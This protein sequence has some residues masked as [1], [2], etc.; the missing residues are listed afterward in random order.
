[1]S[2]NHS[3][4]TPKDASENS[5]LASLVKRFHERLL[6]VEDRTLDVIESELEEAIE[7]EATAEEMARDE[8]DLLGAYLRRDI[9][10][11]RD[12]IA[13]TGKGLKEWLRFDTGLLE[14]R[15]A[16]LLLMVADETTVQ[17]AELRQQAQTDPCFTAG[18]S[19]LG[20]TFSCIDC[21]DVYVYHQPTQL[22]PCIECGGEVFHRISV[23]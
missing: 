22:K 17:Q 2:D 11:L 13:S 9:Q 5:A 20:G 19:V 23:D 16:E 12:Y 3:T 10:S 15:L 7:I 4:Q 8:L 21:G 18:E 1:M 14:N 6:Q